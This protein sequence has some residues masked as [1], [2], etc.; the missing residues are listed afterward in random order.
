M[1]VYISSGSS[2]AETAA[3]YVAKLREAGIQITFDWSA[4]VLE[5]RAAGNAD[6][7]GRVDHVLSDNERKIAKAADLT[8]VMDADIFWYIVPKRASFGAGVEYREAE[9]EDI[10]IVVSGD[11]KQ[12]LFTVDAEHSFAEH[13]DA[14]AWILNEKA[15]EEVNTLECSK[16]ELRAA[17]SDIMIGSKVSGVPESGA[18]EMLTHWVVWHLK[19]GTV[20]KD[21]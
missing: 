15:N 3:H 17:V 2:E 10:P 1:K 5:S 8:A 4:K 7:I 19:R 13:D 12:S 11:F 9:Y 21:A 20:V 16:E 14:L 6:Q 18:I